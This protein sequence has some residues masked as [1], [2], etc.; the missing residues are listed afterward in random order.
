NN[1]LWLKDFL[2]NDIP[3]AR[4][5]LFGY[6]A[7]VGFKRSIAGVRE[8]ADNLLF[9]LRQKRRLSPERPIIFIC[10]SLGGLIVKR[11]LV[12]AKSNR[13]Y[14]PIAHATFG[15]VFFAT[16]HQGTDMATYATVVS[17][18]WNACVD[19]TSNTFLESLKGDSLFA[20]DLVEDYRQS[21]EDYQVLSLFETLSWKGLGV[22]V[23]RKSATLGIPGER[24]RQFAVDADHSNICKFPSPDDDNYQA[25]VTE[26]AEMAENAVSKASQQPRPGTV[27]MEQ[28]EDGKCT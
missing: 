27:N 8:Q 6:N 16:P 23:D 21:L 1:K 11:A 3:N 25:V 20:Q 10:H 5:L 18:I 12:N 9:L 2:P 19:H 14:T 22:I 17:K 13:A 4:V 26:I 28:R 7:N 15:I 24:E